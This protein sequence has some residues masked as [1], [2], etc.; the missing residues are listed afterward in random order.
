MRRPREAPHPSLPL[1]EAAAAAPPVLMI[2]APNV[3]HSSI[4]QISPPIS[5]S[6]LPALHYPFMNIHGAKASLFLGGAPSVLAGGITQ[7]P[8][9]LKVLIFIHKITHKPMTLIRWTAKRPHLILLPFFLIYWFKNNN[10]N[11]IQ[12]L[13]DMWRTGE[14]GADLS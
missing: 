2:C 10:N 5:P 12:L 9:Q 7:C 8:T 3:S 13:L 14:V 11:G 1:P 6:A 4:F